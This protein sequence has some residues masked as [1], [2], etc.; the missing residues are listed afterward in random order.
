MTDEQIMRE[1]IKQA[2]KCARSQDVPV[3]AV[4]VKDGVQMVFDMDLPIV[5][6]L[7]IKSNTLPKCGSV[8]ST[9]AIP[10]SMSLQYT[11]NI[12]LFNVII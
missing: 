12:A 3:G 1:C 8:P 6:L 10:C 5:S 9:Y 7:D 4:V 2:K 11:Y